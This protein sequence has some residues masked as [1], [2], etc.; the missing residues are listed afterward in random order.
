[1]WAGAKLTLSTSAAR[2]PLPFALYCKGVDS[3]GESRF[4]I[5]IRMLI[6]ICCVSFHLFFVGLGDKLYLDHGRTIACIHYATIVQ[7]PCLSWQSTAAEQF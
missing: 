1:M 4:R 5:V 6:F 3:G 7:S 2:R